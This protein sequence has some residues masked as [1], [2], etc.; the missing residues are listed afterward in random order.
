[1]F[2]TGLYGYPELMKAGLGNMLVPWAKCAIWC[3]DNRFP[4]LAP[5]WAKLRIGPYLRREKDKRQ[6]Q[7]FFRRTGQISGLRRLSILATGRKIN[8]RDW[9]SAPP[10]GRPGGGIVCFR[11]MDDPGILAGRH[12]DV[13]DELLRMTKEEYI[14]RDV[15]AG[16]FIGIHVRLGDFIPASGEELKQSVH[17]RRIPL[18]WYAEAL[19]ALRMAVNKDMEARIF[20]DGRDE[21]LASLL[22]I[23]GI[24][25]YEGKTAIT[26][27]LALARAAVIIAS[28]SSFSSWAAYLGN[29]PTVWYPGQRFLLC[30][31]P[32]DGKRNIEWDRG[33]NI[34]KDFLKLIN[35]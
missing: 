11:M 30:P 16:S 5:G 24:S 4:M 35:N 20:S 18:Q 31:G 23:P 1:M 14:P 19:F 2:E 22:G 34:D 8:E 26:D 15:P 9:F 7:A 6:Y 17:S 13:A 32:D 3:R 28:G 12:K 21:E 33:M 25:R 27:M 10:A 29:V